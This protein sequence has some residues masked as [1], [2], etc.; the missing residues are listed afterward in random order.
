MKV[1]SWF[2]AGITSTAATY[3]AL[4]KF[5]RDNVD[6]IFFETGSHHPDNE[7]YIKECEEKLFKKKVQIEHSNKFKDVLDLIRK[8]K[9]INFVNGAECTRT[10]KKNVRFKLEKTNT[11]DYQVFGFE[12]EKKEINRAIRHKEQYGDTNPIFPLIDAKYSKKDCIRLLKDFDIEL[13]MMYRLGYTN[14]NCIGCVKG[15]MGY[16][17]KIRRDFPEIFNEMAKVEREIG[18]T[19]LLET[20]DG[21]R[22]QLYL[23]T[24]DPSRGREEPPITSECGVVCTTEFNDYESPLV[25]KVLSGVPFQQLF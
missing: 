10:L 2:S 14:N 20:V 1:V 4:E 18:R 15:G 7:R 5:G 22:V 13:P 11:W 6:I 9:V 8:L 17:N 25:E 12:F 24:L 19:C 21:K 3:L 23:D 16:W